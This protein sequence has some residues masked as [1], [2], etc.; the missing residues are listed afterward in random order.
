MNNSQKTYP[1][2]F[3]IF[4]TKLLP[5][6][7]T[8]KYLNVLLEV[9]ASPKTRLSEKKLLEFINAPRSSY[10]RYLADLT[11]L[12]IY[13]NKP[14][15]VS[16]EENN[17]RYYTLHKTYLKHFTQDQKHQEFLLS[18][19]AKIAT[20]L[21]NPLLEEEIQKKSSPE[22]KKKFYFITDTNPES[23]YF[24]NNEIKEN[25]IEALLLD[26]KIA[27]TY[28]GKSYDNLLPLTLVEQK[29]SLYLIAGKNNTKVENIR[30]FK[31][32]RIEEIKIKEE[33]FKY[34]ARWKP[35]E[36]FAGSSG[37]I[38][39]A[40]IK[41]EIKVFDVCRKIFK[42]KIILH[43]QLTKRE[44]DFDH[45]TIEFTNI[46]EAMASLFAYAQDIEIIS[47]KDLKERFIQKAQS[48]I[49]RNL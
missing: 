49:S 35:S 8:Q 34:P 36:Y 1:L 31:L 20:L 28:Q 21:K 41:A 23:R 29:R 46:E 25:I 42:E 26:K 40:T 32:I 47:P 15:L 12:P 44:E 19:F 17:K 37:I 30:T 39:G 11:S 24:E 3:P 6:T 18:A 4:K 43:S 13:K 27:I 5:M 2:I 9:L 38:S 22:I 10:Y 33:G 14:L 7:K 45:Y 48:A 16:Y